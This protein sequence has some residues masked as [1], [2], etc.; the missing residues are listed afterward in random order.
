MPRLATVGI[1]K[2]AC[3]RATSTIA[4]ATLR[5]FSLRVDLKSGR[6]TFSVQYTLPRRDRC[7]REFLRFF[8]MRRT[9]IC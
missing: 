8:E 6:K 1:D 9:S 2:K 4:D 5:G 7:G 3:E